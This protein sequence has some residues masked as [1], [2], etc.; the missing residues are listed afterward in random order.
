M[1]LVTFELTG[2][3]AILTMNRPEKRNSL[4]PDL[5]KEFKELFSKCSSNVAIK[6]IIITGAGSSFCAGADLAYL[7]RISVFDNRE[8][9]KDSDEL[10]G[11]FYMIYKCDKLTIAA[12]N[13]PAIAGGCGL[14][15]CTDYIIADR[16][17][18]KFGYTEVKIGFLPAIVSAF[19]IKR[20]GEAKARRML[21]SGEIIDAQT[22]FDYGFADQLSDQTL[23]DALTFAEK[24]SVNSSYSIAETKKLIR[25]IGRLSIEQAI[26]YCVG[27]NAVSRKSDDFIAGINT[28]LNKEK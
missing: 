19:L 6:A 8:N 17:N 21:I 15:S 2:S 1:S 14:A 12:V 27:L 25:E 28:F 24:L 23:K 22:A 10:S 26:E 7:K 18:A 9:Y 4:H 5:V 20:I 13:G 3:T 11:L 16:N